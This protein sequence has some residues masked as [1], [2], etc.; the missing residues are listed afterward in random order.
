MSVYWTSLLAL[1]LSLPT[2]ARAQGRREDQQQ[3]RTALGTPTPMSNRTTVT[4]SSP[5]NGPPPTLEPPAQVLQRAV[6]AYG[7]RQNVNG[8]ADIV[9]EGT[10]TF[11]ASGV[12][13][14]PLPVTM[15]R[16]GDRQ[17]QRT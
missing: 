4:G 9:A 6:D 1:V 15:I 11:Y 2:S 13:Q 5:R 12:A 16:K 10:V 3:R 7:G 8:V 14:Q 17:V